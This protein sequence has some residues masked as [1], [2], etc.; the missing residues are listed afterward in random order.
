MG[1]ELDRT[2]SAWRAGRGLE[3]EEIKKRSDG[4]ANAPMDADR[5]CVMRPSST[6]TMDV[7]RKA[8][9]RDV[10]PWLT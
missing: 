2:K 1:G 8:S 10:L 9:R 7:L 3:G 4:G 6:S 5:R